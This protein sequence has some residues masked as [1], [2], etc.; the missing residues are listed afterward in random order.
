MFVN[1]SISDGLL[2]LDVDKCTVN[3]EIIAILLL[4]RK[5][6]HGYNSNNL[7]WYFDFFSI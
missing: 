4:F 5:M 2:S 3:S 6:Q 7:N 1:I